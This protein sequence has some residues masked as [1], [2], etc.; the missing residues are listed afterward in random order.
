MAGT[1]YLG[2]SVPTTY[3]V[4][5]QLA[6]SATTLTTLYTV[7]SNVA[8]LVSGLMVANRSSTSATFRVAVSPAG[9]AIANQHYIYYDIPLAGGTSF[10]LDVQGAG[11]TLATTDLVRVYASNAN[12]SFSLFGGEVSTV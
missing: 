3:K 12:L 7:P 4:L 11:L 10:L 2:G 1:K 9:A 6:P 5:G 8:T